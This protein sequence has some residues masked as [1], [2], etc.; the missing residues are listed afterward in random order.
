[1]AGSWEEENSR[2]WA[3]YHQW[4]PKDRI[5]LLM[6]QNEELAVKGFKRLKQ[7]LHKLIKI[8]RVATFT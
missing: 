8:T 2:E 1:M 3:L 7:Y 4:S 6:S 5:D